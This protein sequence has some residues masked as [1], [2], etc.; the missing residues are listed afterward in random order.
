[1]RRSDPWSVEDTIPRFASN[2][3]QA[4]ADFNTLPSIPLFLQ[5]KLD[6]PLC[7]GTWCEFTGSPA[8]QA[9]L[10]NLQQ[11][12]QYWA[13]GP[14]QARRDFAREGEPESFLEISRFRC[15]ACAARYYTDQFT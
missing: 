6:W 10:V 5:G 15:T 13:S 11:T 4:W 14:A 3:E 2:A 1:M 8:G 7:C 12:D 9:E